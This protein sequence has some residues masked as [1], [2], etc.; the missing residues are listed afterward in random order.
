[1]RDG[2][3]A[4]GAG[5][6]GRDGGRVVVAM[7]KSRRPPG[8]SKGDLAPAYRA[9]A[10][11]HAPRQ[12]E[13]RRQEDTAQVPRVEVGEAPHPVIGDHA[14]ARVRYEPLQ[15]QDEQEDVIDFAEEWDEV[16]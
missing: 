8:Q 6:A 7:A 14:T 9:K 2:P 10:S 13:G 11:T 3:L 5:E 1:M 12:E 16:G 15:R 4:G